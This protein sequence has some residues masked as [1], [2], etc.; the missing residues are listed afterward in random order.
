MH[1][2]E[3]VGCKNVVVYGAV[4]WNKDEYFLN[5]VAATRAMDLLVWMKPEYK[6]RKRS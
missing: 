5:Y 4:W 1:G 6:K 3:G 2:T